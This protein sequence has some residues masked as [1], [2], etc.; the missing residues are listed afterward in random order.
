MVETYTKVTLVQ[1]R[2]YTKIYKQN[3]QFH[4]QQ[5]DSICEESKRVHLQSFIWCNCLKTIIPSINPDS[6]GWRFKGCD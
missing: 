6:F 4:Y 5:I 2:G 1:A 3:L